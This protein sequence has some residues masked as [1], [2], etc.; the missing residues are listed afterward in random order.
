MQE[1]DQ[2]IKKLQY[3]IKLLTQ[4]I[5]MDTYPLESCILEFDLISLTMC[6]LRQI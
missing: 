6:G 4:T 1:N 5:D 3:Q 2:V